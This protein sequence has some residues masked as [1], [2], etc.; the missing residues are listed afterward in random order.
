[1]QSKDSL[2][3]YFLL[4][5]DRAEFSFLSFLIYGWFGWIINPMIGMLLSPFLFIKYS[6]ICS[7]FELGTIYTK[8]KI[9][10]MFRT[11][12]GYEDPYRK[13][14]VLK[15]L[16]ILVIIIIGYTYFMDIDV[17]NIINSIDTENKHTYPKNTSSPQTPIKTL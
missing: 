11:G 13:V 7:S 6:I 1:M 10:L 4:S 15:K 16:V 5:R 2:Q 9:Y 3:S 12:L 8:K 14:G 17:D